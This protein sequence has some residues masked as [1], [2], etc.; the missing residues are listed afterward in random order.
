VQWK[1]AN[2]NGTIEPNELVALPAQ[3]GTPSQI[4]S[5]WAVG[6][7]LRVDVDTASGRTSVFGEMALGSNMD[8]GMFIADPVLTGIDARELGF[9]VG[10]TQEVM[11]Y[12][13]V[14]FRYD[15]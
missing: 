13:V 12:G 8:R 4:Y 1:D 2:E 14:G 9:S 3:A 5:R 6:G 15:Q 7:D 11:H 10:F